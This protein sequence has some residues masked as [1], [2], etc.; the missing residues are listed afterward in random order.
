[1]L[2]EKNDSLRNKLLLNISYD[3]LHAGD[4]ELFLKANKQAEKLSIRLADTSRLAG[5]YWDLGKY[6]YR[7]PKKDSAYFYY[8]R[9]QKLYYSLE[10]HI[11]AGRLLLNLAIIQKDI[12]DYTGSEV[13]TTNAITLLSPYQDYF[14]LYVAYNNMGIVFNELKEYNRALY[15]QS[16]ALNALRKT[17]NKDRL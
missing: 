8:D 3:A 14:S 6:Y 2:I 9:A 10:D 12:K 15:Y 13:T 16:K 11:S 7:L 1:A 4:D 17:N 5:V